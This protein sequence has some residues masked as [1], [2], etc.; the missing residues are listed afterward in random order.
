MIFERRK[1]STVNIVLMSVL[2]LIIGFEIGVICGKESMKKML[3]NM[4]K[5]FMK[6]ASNVPAKTKK[7][8]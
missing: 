6:M 8:E 2:S 1:M 3:S 4:L 5:E 7:E